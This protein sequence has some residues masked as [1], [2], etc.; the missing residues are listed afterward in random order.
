LRAH[1]RTDSIE[2]VT[3]PA[4]VEQRP[5]R[6]VEDAPHPALPAVVQPEWSER[7]PW[8]VQGTTRAEN[9][10][11]MGLFSGASVPR[12]V[13]ARWDRLRLVTGMSL[14]TC[15]HQVHGAAVRWHAP[16][17]PG[18]HL[19]EPCDG[20]ATA[21]ARTLLGVTVADCVPVSVVD[22]R[23]PAIALLHAGWRGT[24]AGI[25][26]RGVAVLAERA[27][28]RPEEL[29]VHLGPA[30]CGR[31][32]EVGPEVFEALG[33]TVPGRPATLDL[34]ALL[35]GRAIDAGVPSD[36][37]TVST[38][39]T[40]CGDGFFSHRAGDQGRQAGFLGIRGT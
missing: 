24:A 22:P 21:T 18:L 4:P 33:L 40:R 3:S 20:H 7:F 27:S 32:Y 29:H 17:A 39:C 14:A 1:G 16:G 25:L 35:A 10:F 2:A 34:R 28:S 11:D 26:E 5:F 37:I 13:F 15:A 19:F 6:A 38:H 23:G 8:L 12:D 9:D 30:I 36:Q 31:C